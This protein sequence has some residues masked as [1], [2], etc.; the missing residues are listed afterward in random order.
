MAPCTCDGCG[1]SSADTIL[2][3]ARY[4][5]CPD[6][7]PVCCVCCRSSGED[8]EAERDD[9]RVNGFRI[10]NRQFICGGCRWKPADR[11]GG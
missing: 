6:C 4:R 5:F 2:V 11:P 3:S 10:N 1:L 8:E 9:W 7:H